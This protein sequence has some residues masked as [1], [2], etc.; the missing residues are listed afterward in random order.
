MAKRKPKI[1]KDGSLSEGAI[2]GLILDWLKDVGLLHWRQNSGNVFAG[3]RR[4]KLGESGLPD[5]IV[6]APPFGGVVGLEVKS[7]RGKM[8]PDQVAFAAELTKNG[9]RYFVVRSLADAMNAIAEVV[10]AKSLG[11]SNGQG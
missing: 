10:S 8:R 6:I 3:N 5:I 7:A 11:G 9:G 1:L 2:Q 4:I